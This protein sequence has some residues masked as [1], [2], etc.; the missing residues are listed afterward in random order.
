MR[1]MRFLLMLSF[2]A[3][4]LWWPMTPVAQAET[5]SQPPQLDDGW[6]RTAQGWQHRS[7]WQGASLP[8]AG[9]SAAGNSV[10]GNAPAEEVHPLLPFVLILSG[11]VGGIGLLLVEIDPVEYHAF[12]L[13]SRR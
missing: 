11:V 6:R 12:R 1:A 8:A 4:L 2:A 13:K 9:N 10:A 5:A 7:S 3:P